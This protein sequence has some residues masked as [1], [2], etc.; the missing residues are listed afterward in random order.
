MRH[1][2]AG[3]S[4]S[5]RRGYALPHRAGVVGQS[6]STQRHTVR[7]QV[8]LDLQDHQ[9]RLVVRDWGRGFDPSDVPAHRFGLEGIRKRPNWPAAERKSIAHPDK[10]RP[11]PSGC[12]PVAQHRVALSYLGDP[13]LTVAG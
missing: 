1:S 7:A 13:H 4:R 12:G 2:C 10:E 11:L 6:L 5:S 9:V 8:T 3:A